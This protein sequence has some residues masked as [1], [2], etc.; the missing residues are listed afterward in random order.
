[1][2]NTTTFISIF[3]CFV[4]HGF[5][6]S[7]FDFCCFAENFIICELR[8]RF[9]TGTTTRKRPDEILHDLFSFPLIICRQQRASKSESLFSTIFLLFVGMACH[10]LSVQ[11]QV[12]ITITCIQFFQG[13]IKLHDF[14]ILCISRAA[15]RCIFTSNTGRQKAK[16]DLFFSPL[17]SFS[18]KFVFCVV[19]PN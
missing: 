1:M 2:N 17:L 15:N 7:H 10:L 6:L 8:P 5:S 3:S 19:D 12:S 14:S 9:F 18:H 11:I 13:L 16:L 4:H